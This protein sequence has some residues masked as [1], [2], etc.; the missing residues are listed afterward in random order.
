MES[1]RQFLG[2]RQRILGQSDRLFKR[3]RRGK[4]F[5]RK[6]LQR[7]RQLLNLRTS[8]NFRPELKQKTGFFNALVTTGSAAETGECVPAASSLFGLLEGTDSNERIGQRVLI[9]QIHIWGSLQQPKSITA[10]VAAT[11]STAMIAVVLD[12]Q[13]NGQ[14]AQSENV[15]DNITGSTVGNVTVFRDFNNT[16]RFKTLWTKRIAFDS[17]NSVNDSTA[18][19]VSTTFG[20]KLWEVHLTNIDIPVKYTGPTIAV[21]DILN[22]NLLVMAYTGTGIQVTFQYRIRYLDG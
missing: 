21:S 11:P 22:N 13:A 16:E 6:V 12:T 8:G 20:L 2:K 17:G 9:K 3:A 7:A 1:K 15:Y 19:T 18:T 4:K 5:Q 10:A 14:S